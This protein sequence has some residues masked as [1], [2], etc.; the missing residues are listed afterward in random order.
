MGAD[1]CWFVDGLTTVGEGWGLELM[2][3]ERMT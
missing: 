3:L 2:E 1:R